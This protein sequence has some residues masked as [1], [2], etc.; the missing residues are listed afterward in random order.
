MLHLTKLAIEAEAQEWAVESTRAKAEAEMWK[1]NH[2]NQVELKRIISERP[3]LA[4][5]A[6]LVE[7]LIKHRD[8]LLK[9]VH[10]KMGR[11]AFMEFF[12]DDELLGTL[13]DADRLE[14][15]MQ[16]LPGQSDLTREL[17][18][19]LCD[20]YDT[21]L[22]GVL[23]MTTRPVDL[24]DYDAT[25]KLSASLKE[26]CGSFQ[27]KYIAQD[28][29]GEVWAFLELPVKEG[30]GWFG[31]GDNKRLYVDSYAAYW[32]D[33]LLEWVEEYTELCSH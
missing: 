8:E 22:D 2:D 25:V 1:S 32:E 31:G 17:L 15:F 28:K 20:N 26:E 18:E 10:E 23:Q 33:S 7:K 5:R 29:D 9:A 3:D 11:A 16:V 24:N 27:A 12:R 13:M 21:N 14:I 6:T 30:S 4:E 19:E